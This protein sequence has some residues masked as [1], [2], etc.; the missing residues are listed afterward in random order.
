MSD[1]QPTDIVVTLED[2]KP[3]EKIF[4]VEV[5][6]ARCETAEKQA[7]G[8]YAKQVKL[9]G[10]RKGKTP[11]SVIKKKFGQ[12][13]RESVT[14]ELVSEGW[15]AILE[16]EDLKP[17]AEPLVQELKFDEG[18]P[19]IFQVSV[20]V[21]PELDLQ[22]LGGFTLVRRTIEVTDEM[23]ETQ[24]EHLRRQQSPWVPVEGASP[25][26]GE[27]ASITITPLEEEGEAVEGSQY[28]V[29]IGQGQALPDV[30]EQLKKM[31]PGDSTDTTVSFPD[32]FH[33][34]SKRGK[35]SAVRI[36]LHEVKRQDLPELNDDFAKAAGDFDSMEALR[37]TMRADMEGQIQREADTRV[38]Q[39]LIDEIIGANSVEAP[40]PMVQRMLAGLA[41]NYQ[42]PDD[43]LEKFTAEMTPIAEMQVKRNLVIDEVA[44]SKNLIATEEDLDAKVEKI[45]AARDIPPGQVYASLQKAK[46]LPD[47]ER[48]IT[49][50]KV[51][52]YL[53]EQSTVTEQTG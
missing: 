30:E 48:G 24:L 47:M 27:L 25:Q 18:E 41:H 44:E 11:D 2:E 50:E 35:T 16:K 13:I 23:A 3:G 20:A 33:E 28:Q 19:L 45:A 9:P 12:A 22:R 14:Q 4:K 49:E 10:F 29:L 38:R 40:R 21:K 52:S 42:I 32:D 51:F 15:K 31:L 5:P 7:T 53:L 17:I 34:E 1:T 26:E 46:Q 36:A 39:Q 8:E 6:L 37:T 43:Q